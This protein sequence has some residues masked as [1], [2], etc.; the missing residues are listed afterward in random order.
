MSWFN[1]GEDLLA[2]ADSRSKAGPPRVLSWRTRSTLVT[3]GVWPSTQTPTSTLS[4]LRKVRRRRLYIART[5][6]PCASGRRREGPRQNVDTWRAGDE[7][8]LA[9]QSPASLSSPALI[10]CSQ[11]PRWNQQHQYHKIQQLRSLVYHF[12][13]APTPNVIPVYL[14]HFHTVQC[15]W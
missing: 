13:I 11:L 15:R 7:N 12:W 1:N 8:V 5:L 4:A 6:N 2:G 10:T 9:Y 3:S 14:D